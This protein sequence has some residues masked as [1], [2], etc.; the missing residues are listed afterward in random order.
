[1]TLGALVNSLDPE[2]VLVALHEDGAGPV[3]HPVPKRDIRYGQHR[4]FLPHV[5]VGLL[6]IS[7]IQKLTNTKEDLSAIPLL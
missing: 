6:E 1:M 5:H 2:D 3:H 7:Q 4:A